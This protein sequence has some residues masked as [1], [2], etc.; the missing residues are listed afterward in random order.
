[1]KKSFKIHLCLACRTTALTGLKLELACEHVFVDMVLA[2]WRALQLFPFSNDLK[3]WRG[4]SKCPL[5][6]FCTEP[7]SGRT[8]ML[9]LVCPDS[10]GADSAVLFS[11]QWMRHFW[12]EMVVKPWEQSLASCLC[13]YLWVPNLL[14]VLGCRSVHPQQQFLW[15]G[16]GG[17]DSIEAIPVQVCKE[18]IAFRCQWC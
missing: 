16:R 2:F 13:W 1:M 18:Q 6:V 11:S 3:G 12:S 10:A 15:W 8:M 14:S 5:K 7:L 17:K 9:R 4:S